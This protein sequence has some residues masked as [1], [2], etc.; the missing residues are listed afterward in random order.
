MLRA[1]QINFLKALKK[2]DAL[3]QSQKSNLHSV[4]RP[5]MLLESLIQLINRRIEEYYSQICTLR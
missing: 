2:I 3:F 5:L 1:T 4:K